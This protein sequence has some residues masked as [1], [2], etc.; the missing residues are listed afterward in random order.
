[1]NRSTSVVLGRDIRIMCGVKTIGGIEVTFQWSRYHVPI[2]SN[3][4]VK[5]TRTESMDRLSKTSD[6]RGYLTITGAQYSDSGLYTCHIV[7]TKKDID[8]KHVILKVKGKQ[9]M[10]MYSVAVAVR[11]I[12]ERSTIKRT[13]MSFW[14]PDCNHVRSLCPWGVLPRILD[15]VCREGS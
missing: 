7:G 1:M 14:L 4:H 11:K 10:L 3:K 2:V 13:L 9:I 8:I 5:I 12:K 15:G 6:M